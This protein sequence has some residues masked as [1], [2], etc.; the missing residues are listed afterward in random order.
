MLNSDF[1][2]LQ[3]TRNFRGRQCFIEISAKR[4]V[5][6]QR[7]KVWFKA[8]PVHKL[9]NSI[10]FSILTRPTHYPK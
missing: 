2:S 10:R 6:I 9:W 3:V 7:Q 5:K 1:I 8:Q 4:H